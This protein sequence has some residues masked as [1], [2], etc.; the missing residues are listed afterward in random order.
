MPNAPTGDPKSHDLSEFSEKLVGTCLCGSITVTITDSELFAK[1]RGHLCY[2]ANCRKTSGSYVGSNLLIESE[3]VHFEDRDGTLKT[4]EDRNTLS[5]NPVYRSFCGN[6]GNP[7]RSETELYPGKVV[8]KMGI[9]P[10]IPQPEAEG[11]GL[12]KHPWQTTHEGVET[13][14]IKWAGPEKKRM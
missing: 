3:K 12:H 7:L 2:C 11:F 1:R 14:E 4:Y 10:R 8:L 6:C 13:Y 5:G 9:F